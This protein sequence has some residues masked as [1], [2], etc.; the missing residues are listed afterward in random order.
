MGDGTATRLCVSSAALFLALPYAAFAQLNVS[1]GSFVAADF[2]SFA[3]ISLAASASVIFLLASIG[4]FVLRGTTSFGRL[5]AA[6]SIMLYLSFTFAVVAAKLP[7]IPGLKFALVV[8]IGVVGLATLY[9]L[10]RHRRA[11][12]AVAII[13]AASLALTTPSLFRVAWG[14]TEGHAMIPTQGASVRAA[15]PNIYYFVLDAYAGQ[16]S[17]ARVLGY[18]NSP[19]IDTMLAR[20][21]FNADRALGSYNLT[22]LTLG[23][24]F[25]LDYFFPP[26]SHGQ[27]GRTRRSVGYPKVLNEERSPKLVSEARALG[28]EFFIVGNEWGQCGGAFVSC[29]SD[30]RNLA[31][32]GRTFWS[33]TPIPTWL[34]LKFLGVDQTPDVD[35]IAKLSRKLREGPGLI[36]PSFIFIHHL[37]PHPPYVFQGDCR[38]REKYAVDLKL[39]SNEAKPYYLDNLACTNIKVQ[40]ITDQILQADPSAI[41]VFQGD[42]GTAFT[43]NWDDPFD[44]W[45]PDA[46]QERSSILNLVRLPENCQPLLVPELDNV[47]TA[48]AVLSCAAGNFISKPNIL[49]FVSTYSEKNPDNGS[50]RRVD[51][52]T[53]SLLP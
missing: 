30:Q 9:Q 13:G 16:A 43:V 25:A 32:I 6:L 41:I 22:R 53:M 49:S 26:S 37:S 21:F 3:A 33:A 51:P 44:R 5:V 17:L 28:Y 45:K 48:R 50:A 10:L 36:S 27:P 42:H 47:N 34:P 12:V 2:L 1:D 24:I 14:A 18:D 31:Y 20:G 15:K 11:Q 40:Q 19:F 8:T 46:V 35:A 4:S 52:K 7:P 23:S 29:F 39:W 38:L